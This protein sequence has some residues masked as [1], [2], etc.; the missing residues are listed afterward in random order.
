MKGRT[1]VNH[2]PQVV[3]PADNRPLVAPIYQSVK[4]AF[5]SLE[6]TLRAERGERPGFTYTRRAN[7][8]TRQLERL[9]AEL[10][11]RDDCIVFGS[12]VAA[13]AASLLALTRAGDHVLCFVETYGPSRQLL[14]GLLGRFGVLHTMLTIEDDA[15]IERVLAE[16]PTRLVFFESP[17]N[18]L[19]RIAD[20]AA[21]TRAAHAHGALTVLDNTFAGFHNHGQYGIDVFVHSL[22]KY[23]AGHGD[24]M[25][26]AIIARQELSD[27]IR[28]DAI[29]LGALLDPHA[30]FLVLRGMRTYYLRYEAQAASALAIAE[31]LAGHPA[32]ACVHYPGLPGHP[33]HALAREQMHDFG[34]VVSFDLDL[35][36]D[37]IRDFVDALEFFAISPSLGSV[38]SLVLPPQLLRPRGLSADQAAASGIG[39]GTV[40][41]SIGIEDTGDLI[42]DLEA[43]LAR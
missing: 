13:V 40:R 11:G 39:P 15:G 8:T 10:Q 38:E 32:V 43:A 12:G 31:F 37:G 26:G 29:N 41:L 2:P 33:R 5:D 28:R 36:P 1:R 35:E 14:Q 30:A 4:F 21:I 25:G 18:P 17:T 9:L 19:T 6:E 20:L 7:P 22:T 42:T 23:A 24:V 16:R 3:V 34:A 27:R